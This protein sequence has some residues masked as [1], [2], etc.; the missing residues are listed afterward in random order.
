MAMDVAIIG[1]LLAAPLF[2]YRG[3]AVNQRFG[4]I[5]GSAS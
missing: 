4:G 3:S 1:G 2:T 5:L